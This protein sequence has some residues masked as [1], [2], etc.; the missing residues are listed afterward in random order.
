MYKEAYSVLSRE[1]QFIPSG[2]RRRHR[3]WGGQDRQGSGCGPAAMAIVVSSLTNDIV[4]LVE[5]AEWAYE[6]G[7]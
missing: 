5:M 3:P 2:Q 7:G 4:D 1:K 6:N